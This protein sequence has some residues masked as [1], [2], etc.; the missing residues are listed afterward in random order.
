MRITLF[1]LLASLISMTPSMPSA[2]AENGKTW[3]RPTFFHGYT[4]DGQL[5]TVQQVSEVTE[6]SGDPDYARYEASIIEYLNAHP[7][8]VPLFVYDDDDS[9]RNPSADGPKKLINWVKDIPAVQKRLK[10]KTVAVI[11]VVSE[12]KPVKKIRNNPIRRAIRSSYIPKTQGKIIQSLVTFAFGGLNTTIMLILKYDDS[13]LPLFRK[14]LGGLLEGLSQG[15][16]AFYADQLDRLYTYGIYDPKNP[17]KLH[18]VQQNALRFIDTFVRTY[19]ALLPLEGTPGRDSILDKKGVSWVANY[20]LDYT[21]VTYFSTKTREKFKNYY[22]QE[23]G[24]GLTQ[25]YRDHFIPLRENPIEFEYTLNKLARTSIFENP[26]ESLAADLASI[27]AEHGASYTRMPEFRELFSKFE[28]IV[29]HQVEERIKVSGGLTLYIMQGLMFSAT[30]QIY[31]FNVM[32]WV[33]VNPSIYFLV[34][35]GRALNWSLVMIFN[36]VYEYRPD[37]ALRHTDFINTQGKKLKDGIERFRS[38]IQWKRKNTPTP[39]EALE[40]N[41]KDVISQ[42]P[43]TEEIYLKLI[44]AFSAKPPE[45]S[46]D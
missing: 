30:S 37:I 9:G 2:R 26:F 31:Y 4:A 40:S 46:A 12:S 32:P 13:Q 34:T 3:I 35:A 7:E 23:R 29:I 21:I 16:N 1:F 5:A 19:V 24:E 36:L 38:Y 18:P 41:C 43:G 27:K 22:L 10:E 44:D 42:P 33:L 17:I 20:A 6:Y 39:Q 45:P 14:V 28:T 8:P 15:H 11:R 25:P